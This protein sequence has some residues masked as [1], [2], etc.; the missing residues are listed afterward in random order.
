MDGITKFIQLAARHPDGTPTVQLLH[1]DT[2]EKVAARGHPLIKQAAA[3]L[4]QRE[5]GIWVLLNA[6]SGG[7][8]WGSNTNGD[9]FP[10]ESLKF[11]ADMSFTCPRLKDYGFKTFEKY[12]Y[13]YRHH[14]NKDV[15]KSIGEIVKIAVWNDDMKRV[16]LIHFLRRDSVFDDFGDVIKVGAPDLVRSVEEGDEVSVSMGCKV[17]YDICSKCH[18]KAKN[19]TL[20]CDHLKYAMNQVMPD[21]SQI[22]AIN[23]HPK[24]FDISY[25]LRGAEKTAK[26]LKNLSLNLAEVKKEASSKTYVWVAEGLEKAASEKREYSLPS[27]YY[28]EMV[29][30]AQESHS[31]AKSATITKKVPVDPS[32][33]K[34]YGDFA[35]P[36]LRSL[37]PNLPGTMLT[38]MAGYE[39]AE[40][41][42]TMTG[43]GMMLHPQE[44]RR[45]VVIKIRGGANP[46]DVGAPKVDPQHIRPSLIQLLK[47][48]LEKRSSFRNPLRRRVQDLLHLNGEQLLDKLAANEEAMRGLEAIGA[49][50]PGVLEKAAPLAAL[51][52]ALYTLYR[53][54]ILKAPLPKFLEQAFRSLPELPAAII[55]AGIG[56]A[57]GLAGQALIQG[58]GAGIPKE[59]SRK[60]IATA[61]GIFAAPYLYS[62]YVQQKALKG[63]PIGKYEASA[64]RHP[65]TLGI[66][67]L[68]AY[69]KRG[70]IGKKLVSLVKGKKSSAQKAKEFGLKRR[71]LVKKAC[72]T[73]SDHDI[74]AYA[75]DN[76]VVDRAIAAGLAKIAARII[77]AMKQPA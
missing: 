76:E 49:T 51:S 68:A 67:G 32:P 46:D 48:Q 33:V 53:K 55:G 14:V 43:M 30:S 73:I 18:Q 29:K 6:V 61:A 39:L 8:Y 25:V 38:R 37:E 15:K 36:M 13:P 31:E 58:F 59:A 10:E 72:A 57:F 1:P 35:V 64:A 69:L 74:L 22:Y 16:E 75:S 24:F 27:A 3:E 17:P 41:C 21:G 44:M 7:E 2:M 77:E 70:A 9:F 54:N 62:G 12:A 52:A 60:G 5:D 47:S 26:V 20:Y 56:G 65:G 11:A 4:P 45:I 63:E 40:I 28:A 71:P 66:A 23:P 19:V 34:G 42:S 50:E